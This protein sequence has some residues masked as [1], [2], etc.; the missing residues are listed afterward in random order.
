MAGVAFTIP[1]LLYLGSTLQ[2]LL[3]KHSLYRYP[4]TEL[5][6]KQVSPYARWAVFACNVHRNKCNA[7]DSEPL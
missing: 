7:I 1:L 3:N 5:A 6:S 4:K 2:L